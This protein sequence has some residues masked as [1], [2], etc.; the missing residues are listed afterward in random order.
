MTRAASVTQKWAVTDAQTNGDD[1]GLWTNG[2]A[3]SVGS[4]SSED[5]KRHSFNSGSMLTEYDDG[6]AHLMATATNRNGRTAEISVWFDDRQETSL[7]IKRAVAR[8]WTHGITMPISKK[9][10]RL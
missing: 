6:T 1:H 10:Q 2:L 7:K 4:G 5:K 3:P 9:T 8:Y